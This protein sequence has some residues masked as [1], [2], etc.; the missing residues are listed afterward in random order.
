MIALG[1][2]GSACPGWWCEEVTCKIILKCRVGD[3][4]ANTICFISKLCT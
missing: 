4:D 2:D 1:S 3:S